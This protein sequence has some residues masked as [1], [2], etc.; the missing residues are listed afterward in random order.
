[1]TKF[2]IGDRVRIN[3]HG[4]LKMQHERMVFGN[5]KVGGYA[6]RRHV[7]E[8][9]RRIGVVVELITEE[10]IDVRWLP[11]NLRYCYYVGE[12][13]LVADWEFKGVK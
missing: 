8:F 3:K 4:R 2:K 5:G 12:L 13:E 10:L 7:Q 9:R 1:M 11:G 6:Q